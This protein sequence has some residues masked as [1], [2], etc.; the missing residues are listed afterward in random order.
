MKYRNILVP[1][2]KSKAA[3]DAVATA[4]DMMEGVEGAHITVLIVADDGLAFTYATGVAE[5]EHQSALVPR[6]AKE[7]EEAVASLADVTKDA[8]CPIET[9][10]ISGKPQEIVPD[11]AAKKGFDL[12]VMGSRG[13]GS[14]TGMVGSVSKAVLHDTT[15][16]VLIVR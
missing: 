9:V 2:D 15:T 11:Y 13:L 8:T 12:I 6:L 14:F 10:L 1:Y 5:V 3:K 4:L 7:K 16:P